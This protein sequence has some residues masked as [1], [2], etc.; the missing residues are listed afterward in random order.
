MVLAG[1]PANDVNAPASM[2]VLAGDRPAR[3]VWENEAGGLTFE[4]GAGYE[5]CF[6]KWAPAGTWFVTTRVEGESAVGSVRRQRERGRGRDAA[7][8]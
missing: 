1:P 6:V 2:A 4:V 3:C 7:P 5:R 8:E